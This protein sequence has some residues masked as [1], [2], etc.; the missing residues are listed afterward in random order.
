ME[1]R[2]RPFEC[3]RAR[4][5]LAKGMSTNEETSVMASRNG[6][7]TG[8]KCAICRL[9]LRAVHLFSCEEFET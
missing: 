2:K 7:P 6:S 1:F 3:S 4:V 9:D 5:G 8:G